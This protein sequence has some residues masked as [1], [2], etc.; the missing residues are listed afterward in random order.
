VKNLGSLFALVDRSRRARLRAAKK[1]KVIAFKGELLL[2]GVSD[3]V[4]IELLKPPPDGMEPA[5]VTI[6]SNQ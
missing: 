3:K 1:R 5:T 4:E 6:H 2:K